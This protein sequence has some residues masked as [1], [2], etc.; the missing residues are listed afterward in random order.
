MI[1]TDPGAGRPVERGSAV[2]LFVS[3]GPEQVA[4]PNVTGQDA[5]GRGR[6]CA[7]RAS[8][9]S[10]A[11]RPRASR[12]APWS[13][14]TPAAGQQV[15]EGSTVTIFVS[16]GKVKRGARRDRAEPGRGRGASSRDAGFSAERADTRTT[17]QPDEDGSCSPSR[18]AA[19]RSAREG[20]TVTITVGSSRRPRRRRREPRREGRGARR[21]AARA[22]IR[23]RSSPAKSVLDGLEAGGH[24]TLPVVI[25]RE[26]ALAAGRP[27][28]DRRRGGAAA[29]ARARAAGLLGRGRRV[30]GPARAVRRGRHG[31]GP[32]RVRSTCPTSAPACWRRRSAWTRRRSS[33]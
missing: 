33:G 17:D 10:C 22:S 32:A 7:R 15:D 6:R 4:V 1:R 8:A 16:N 28:R 9:P 18:P 12:R 20:A 25:G 26:G 13:S 19:A 23:S 21:A 3:S 30:P 31:P 14:Q 11:R 24:E 2:T 5:G 27:A 29:G